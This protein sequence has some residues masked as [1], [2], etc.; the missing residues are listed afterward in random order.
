[1][2]IID[3]L[4]RNG[5]S[6]IARH[7][8]NRSPPAYIDKNL[9]GLQDLIVDHNRVRRLKAGMALDDRTIFQFLATNPLRPYS[10]ARR[11]HPCGLSLA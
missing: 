10:I 4:V 5:T 7:I 1:M 6:W 8:G 11:L 9:V 3:E 2:S